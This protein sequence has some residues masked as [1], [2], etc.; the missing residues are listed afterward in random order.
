MNVLAEGV[1]LDECEL[2]TDK[3]NVHALWEWT[4]YKVSVYELPLEPH[5]TCIGAILSEFH[6]CCREVNYTDASI[7]NLGA[8]RTRVDRSGKGAD[9]SFRPMKPRVP[10][11]TGSDG[12]RKSWPNII[13]EV[14]YIESIEYVFDKVRNYW[15]KDLSRA[16]DAIVVKID[17][18]SDLHA[19]KRTRNGPIQHRTHFEFGTHDGA[20]DPLNILQGT[21][22]IKI[23]LD[24]LY[25]QAHPDVRIP[26][27][28]LPDS[29]VLDFFFVRDEI[30]C[31]YRV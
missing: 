22:L 17:P 29:I 26:R 30:L 28:I 4:N 16:H 13:V 19:C 25:H 12:N 27:T 5:E 8:T 18:I 21:C 7:I 11:P 14:A 15:L 9:A 31:A 1:T 6:E 3:F 24:C 23:D 10:A 2:R 20:G